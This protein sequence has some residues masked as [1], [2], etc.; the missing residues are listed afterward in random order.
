MFTKCNSSTDKGKVFEAAQ[1]DGDELSAVLC[2]S[3]WYILIIF[4]LLSLAMIYL[5]TNSTNEHIDCV[6]HLMR[7]LN[8]GSLKYDTAFHR[9]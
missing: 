3:V 1:G 4:S 6:S 5:H 9:F 8:L 7:L 2:N